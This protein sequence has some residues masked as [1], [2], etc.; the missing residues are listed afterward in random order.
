MQADGGGG[1][2]SA[3]TSTDHPRD[4]QA[5]AF[6]GAFFLL[7]QKPRG[8]RSW[9]WSAS[10]RPSG[11]TTAATLAQSQR[12][13][14]WGTQQVQPERGQERPTPPARRSRRPTAAR[15]GRCTA[16]RRSR[17]W[18]GRGRCSDAHATLSSGIGFVR[19]DAGSW[20]E[21]V[22]LDVGDHGLALLVREDCRSTVACPRKPMVTRSKMKSGIHA[23]RAELRGLAR[24]GAV[25]MAMPALFAPDL[26]AELDVRRVVHV[27]GVEGRHRFFG[28]RLGAAASWAAQR[29]H[30]PAPRSSSV[31]AAYMPMPAQQA[32]VAFASFELVS[33]SLTAP[34]RKR[35]R[36]RG[37]GPRWRCCRRTYGT[38]L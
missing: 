33:R 11:R 17:A 18:P 38:I 25:A 26:L 6:A 2:V 34:L 21:A 3:A 29:C 14:A 19:R 10:R 37:A 23:A 32:K 15:R 12:I 24:V 31:T 22:A 28:G 20:R 27:G 4:H 9:A 35:N 7:D 8:A 36:H 13:P 1:A 30:Q 5:H 16:P